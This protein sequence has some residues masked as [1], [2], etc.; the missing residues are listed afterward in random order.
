MKKLDY[1]RLSPNTMWLLTAPFRAYFSPVFNG[2]SNIPD[3]GPFL[4]VGNHTI[5][6]ISDIPLI[7]AGLCREKGIYLRMLADKFHFLVP[8]WG[9]LVK[10]LGGVKGTP[11]NCADLME[12]RENIMVFP[13]GGREVC[14]RRGE[15]YKLIWKERAGFV[16]MAVQHGYRILPMASV[17][18][19]NAWTILYDADD[20]LKSWM[21]KILARKGIVRGIMRNGEAIPPIAR[22]IGPT[23]IPRPERFYFSFGKPIDTEH[24]KG[25]AND[26]AVLYGIRKEVGDSITDQIG[27]LLI[28]REQ[29][30]N[31]GFLRRT[32]TRL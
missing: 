12:A 13:G 27:R 16:R 19:E 14:K 1:V 10:A 24:F 32:L 18:P 2:L 6:G 31:K 15:R 5:Y 17:G 20:F 8:V 29:D 3:H 9:D 23:I 22:G 21:G 28:E 4:F 7:A 30:M 26:R 11:K 25:A